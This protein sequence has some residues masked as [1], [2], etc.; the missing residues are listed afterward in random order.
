MVLSLQRSQL[1]PGLMLCLVL[2]LNQTVDER[3]LTGIH[4]VHSTFRATAIVRNKERVAVEREK[5]TVPEL[6]QAAISFSLKN[7]KSRQKFAFIH[8]AVQA[9]MRAKWPEKLR[10]DGH[11]T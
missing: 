11:E 5:A 2:R 7:N 3:Q 4:G 1:H 10:K 6:F 8:M 9:I